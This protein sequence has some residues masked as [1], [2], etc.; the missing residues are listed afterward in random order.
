MEYNPAFVYAVVAVQEKYGS[1]DA[2]AV[3]DL[4]FGMNSFE[5]QVEV[6]DPTISICGMPIKIKW[7]AAANKKVGPPHAT[8]NFVSWIKEF[9]EQSGLGLKEA[10]DVGDWLKKNPI[11]TFLTE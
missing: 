3:F 5:Y 8:Q 2:K 6:E 7:I 1:A 10:K 9:R 11:N 4:L